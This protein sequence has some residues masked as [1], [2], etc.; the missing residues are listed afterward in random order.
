MG[1]SIMA[2][3]PS[4]ATP[5][6]DKPSAGGFDPST[7][8]PAESVT[9][10]IEGGG[11]AAFGMYPRS[12]PRQDSVSRLATHIGQTALEAAA[13]T[14]AGFAGAGMGAAV[15]APAATAALTVPVV[16]VPLG[17]LIEFGGV[18]GGAMGASWVTNL[19]QNYAYKSL[20]PKGYAERQAE[21]EEY[22]TATFLTELGVGMA[23]MSP[24]TA[25][26]VLSKDA[27]KVARLAATPAGQR[28]I[29]GGL[30]GG[31]EA[32][33]EL[34][35]KGTVEPWKVATATAAGAAM[36]GFN[37]AGKIPFAA[38]QKLGE[39]IS[40]KL[41]GGVKPTVDTTTTSDTNELLKKVQDPTTAPEEKEAVLQKLKDIKTQRDATAPLVEAGMRNTKTGEELRMGPKHDEAKKAEHK[42]NPDWQEGF[43]DERG[44]FLTRK[45]AADRAVN[46]KQISTEEYTSKE[47]A[48]ESKTVESI[49]KDLEALQEKLASA[50]R[51]D[52][53]KTAADT[54]KEIEALTRKLEIVKQ[55]GPT[56]VKY[57]DVT[58]TR[59]KL[60]RP[61]D[62]LHSGDLRAHG[63]ERF[64][65]TEEQP[66]G[67]AKPPVEPTAPKTRQEFKDAVTKNE[68]Q[69][70][71]LELAAEKAAAAGDEATVTKLNEQIKAL[72]A[73]HQ[74]LYKDIPAVEFANLSKPTWEELQDHL[75]NAKTV[76][77][78]FDTI[79]ATKGLGSVGQRL[80]IKAL[81]ESSFIRNADLSFSKDFIKY[82]DKLGVEQDANGMY[83]GGDGVH[84]IE[85][86][87][88]GDV[89][90]LLHEAM[91]AGTQKLLTEGNSTAAKK[92]QELFE[93]YKA[94]HGDESY[95][96][97]DVHEFVSEAFT[98][99]KFQQ[100]L[101]SIQAGQQPK[102][103]ANNI[104]AAFKETVRLGLGLPEGT[105]TALDEV[106]DQG[107]SL[108][109]KSKDYTAGTERVAMP[110]KTPSSSGEPVEP[111]DRTK[112]DPRDVKDDKEMYEIATDIFE[113]YGDV[114]A[115]KFYE[116]YKAYEKTK[117]E[118]VKTTEQFVG[119]NIKNKLANERIVHNNERDIKELAGNE[120]N[121][122]DLTYQIDRGETLTGKAKEVADKFRALMDDL[123]KRALENDVIR[124]WHENYVA[125]N[126]VSEGSAPP[127]AVKEL[128]QDLFGTGGKASDP[129]SVTKYG[130]ERRLKTREDLVR[131]LDGINAW[132]AK[133]GKDYRFKLKTDNLAEIYKDYA[134]AIEKT[135]ENKKLIDNLLYVKNP[136]N[137]SL[138]RPITAE[139]PLPYGWKVMDNSELAG[140]AVHPD[141]EPALRFVFDAGPSDTMKALGA[142]SQFAKRINVIGSFF[143]AKSLMEVMS[144]AQIPIWTPLKEAVV[145]PLVERGVRAATGK[146]LQLSAITKAVEQFK[147]GGVGDSVDLWIKEGGLQLDAPED[148]SKNI[149]SSLGKFA[150]SMVGKFGPKT[151]VLESTMSTVEKYTLG[152]FDK[153][154]WD[155]LH[156]GGKIMVAEAY[157]DKARQQAAK[158]GKPFDE[159]ASRKEISK[160]VNDSFGGLNWFDAATQTQNEFAK[161]IAMA[162]YSP[163]GRRGLQT[164]LFAPDWTIST[165]RAFTA[166]V[167][168]SLDVAAGVKGLAAPATKSDYARMYQI[169]TALTYLT[170]VNA[171]NMMTADR[172]IWENK[173]PTRIEFPDG[174][175]MQAMKHAMEPYHWIMDPDKTLANKLGFI[176]KALIVGIGGLEYASPNAPKLV[177]RGALS[178]GK[179]ALEGLL[180][181]QVSAAMSAPEGE[182]AK[183]ALLGT[184]GLPVYGATAEQR[185]LQRAERELATKEQAWKYRD[186]EIKAGRMPSTP[187]HEKQRKSLEK[188]REKLNK[189]TGKE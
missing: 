124:G 94:S 157:L 32:G 174:T 114:E 36:P 125:R 30:Q 103:V 120:I 92:M 71:N 184:M 153:Y 122:E 68:D 119:T 54:R 47:V 129:K 113:K 137:E 1:A 10:P 169:K 48:A 159:T 173:D 136:N 51:T 60:E 135:I 121:L 3:D 156:T 61:E 110:S 164:I 165:L 76:G 134:L 118:P 67:T 171:I 145:L 50:E 21:K 91:H 128:M 111:L 74:Q 55:Y 86:A 132:L 108:V 13:P 72:E 23:G 130:E 147:S 20:A 27:G 70:V 185:K 14:I 176:P 16:G 77:Q 167:P 65:I 123:G 95:G 93:K 139:N 11:G 88:E 12:T 112:T 100:L 170:L 57:K 44:N 6:E 183:R 63:D 49:T 178:R 79:I 58:K 187:E 177:D 116:G 160:F 186:K 75:W 182:G 143:H 2:F 53:Y 43:F 89:Q 179:A 29:S 131:H 83:T 73:E 150:D 25:V 166:A 96:F 101:S 46:T 158:E 18:L 188:Q 117:L 163:A 126:V 8:K 64:K 35:D 154:T 41:P 175:S 26:N 115:I 85:L 146:E 4:T 31:I 141:L 99:K 162:A 87:K 133:E 42:D 161:R 152:L 90:T 148:V 127:N 34:A 15:V 155:Y 80:L 59:A 9:K 105:R 38:G 180:P 28:V 104:W 172:P 109:K 24:K 62:G 107:I 19:A 140:Y 40:S 138:I 98:N 37:V 45:E 106:F 142:I 168:K 81:N 22:P 151:R 97:T 7:A 69:R 17:G 39:K 149:L 144:S 56:P 82:T 78:A 181:F 84:R 52:A 66:A 102:G 189:Q 5:V 33:T